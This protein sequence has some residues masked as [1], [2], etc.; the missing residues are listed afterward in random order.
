MNTINASNAKPPRPQKK[1]SDDNEPASGVAIKE[2]TARQLL[3]KARGILQTK[4]NNTEKISELQSKIGHLQWDEYEKYQVIASMIKENFK[5]HEGKDAR[6]QAMAQL[7]A[8]KV[9]SK[10]RELRDMANKMISDKKKYNI[11]SVFISRC[12][13]NVGTCH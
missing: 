13:Y 11:V 4:E 7:H 2:L 3:R 9:A 12:F 8:T 5:D 1:T 6:I 10:D